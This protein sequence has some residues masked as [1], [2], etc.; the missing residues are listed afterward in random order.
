MLIENDAPWEGPLV[1]GPWVIKTN[2]YYYLFYSGNV[3][4]TPNYAVG[5]ARST[6]F[7]GRLPRVRGGSAC[8]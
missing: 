5:V 8:L 1:E 4:S 6:N 2:G 7:L 3:Y